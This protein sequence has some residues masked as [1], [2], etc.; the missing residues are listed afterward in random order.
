MRSFSIEGILAEQAIALR[1]QVLIASVTRLLWDK[2][3]TDKSNE[4]AGP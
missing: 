4:A 3:W 1:R 2:M